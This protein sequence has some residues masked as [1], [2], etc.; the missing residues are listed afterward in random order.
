MSLNE[1]KKI[2]DAAVAKGMGEREINFYCR[3]GHNSV[4]IVENPNIDF[5]IFCNTGVITMAI[6]EDSKA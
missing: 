1:F 4:Y 5:W 6:G 3:D 2:V